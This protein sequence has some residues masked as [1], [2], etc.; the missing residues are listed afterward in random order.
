MN[1]PTVERMR[2][3]R[4]RVLR[5]A[6]SLRMGRFRVLRRPLRSLLAR[7]LQRLN[8]VLATSELAGR[9]WVFGGLLLGWAREGSILRHDT[10]DADFAIRCEDLRSLYA[11]VPALNRAGFRCLFRFSNNAD[12]VTELTFMRRGAKFEFF[13]MKPEN[14]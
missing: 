8:D 5:A 2:T 13:G 4:P 11:S 10:R 6:I 14:G 9:Y 1:S 7:D 12:E 3:L